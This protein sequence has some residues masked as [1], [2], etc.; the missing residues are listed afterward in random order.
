M[1]TLGD[2]VH[3]ELIRKG[4]D[5]DAEQ[6]ERILTDAGVATSATTG[7]PV[8]L[9]VRRVHVTG[10]KLLEAD[11]EDASEDAAGDQDTLVPFALD[12]SPADGVNGVGSERNLR[13]KSSVLHFM[14][15]R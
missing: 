15:G 4:L 13:G 2:A 9:R 7:V 6:V 5:V 12:W 11:G 1:S 8:R 3:A 14:A 10:T